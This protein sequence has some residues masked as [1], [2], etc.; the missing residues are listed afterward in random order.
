MGCSLFG[1]EINAEIG[2]V[3][4]ASAAIAAGFVAL[5]QYR[6]AER[7]R[8][9]EFAI[10]QIRLLASDETL[11]F[12]C[13]ALDWGLGPLLVPEQ[14]QKLFGEIAMVEHDWCLMAKALRPDL[15][16]DWEK[17]KSH[18]LLYRYA[19]D[20]LFGYLEG[21][22][23]YR[24]LG[25]IREGDLKPITYYLRALKRPEYWESKRQDSD[26]EEIKT[27]T[28]EQLFGDFI[29]AYYKETVWV[30]VSKQ[31]VEAKTVVKIRFRFWRS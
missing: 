8:R 19:F 20:D 29:K 16:R 9:A 17:S 5:A 3:L 25:V 27:L 6:K 4:G 30:W 1:V 12:C 15:H 21:L 13:R 28:P 18:F 31:E 23:M 26:D 14:Y 11:A 22:A 24:D 2:A 10:S 7:W